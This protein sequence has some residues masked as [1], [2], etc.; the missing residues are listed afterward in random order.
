MTPLLTLD[1]L[2][3]A[4][5]HHPLMDH[6]SLQ[7]EPNARICLVGRNGAGKSS[8]MKVIAG[9][10]TADDGSIWRQEGLNIAY[11]AQEVPLDDNRS[12]FDVVAE[13]LGEASRL[14]TDYHHITHELATDPS[15]KNFNIM[16]RL[17][18]QLEAIDGWSL[19]QRVEQTLTRLSL[20]PDHMLSQL[21]GGLRRR[22]LLARALVSEPDLLLL[23]EPDRKSVV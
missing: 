1:N 22:V 3:L 20:N 13:G 12:V 8:M 18:E 17:Q 11:L 7:I 21:S 10:I 4:F 2:S 15:E 23:D 14:I 6:I 19:E 5:G 16:S 9:E